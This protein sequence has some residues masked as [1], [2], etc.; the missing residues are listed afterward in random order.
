MSKL[1]RNVIQ[2]LK[3][4]CGYT[5]KMDAVEMAELVAEEMED[6]EDIKQFLKEVKNEIE[7]EYSEGELI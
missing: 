5:A 2:H 7:L 4:L 1:K 6:N 3:G